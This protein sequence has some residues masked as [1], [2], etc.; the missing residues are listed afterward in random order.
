LSYRGI[1]PRNRIL[2]FFAHPGND[3]MTNRIDIVPPLLGLADPIEVVN[4]LRKRWRARHGNVGYFPTNRA[5]PRIEACI[6]RKLAT[7]PGIA[8]LKSAQRESLRRLAREGAL[9]V[10]P[11]TA[12]EV[13]ELIAA[14]HAEAPWMSAVSTAI[15]QQLLA[16]LTTGRS[17][18]LLRPILLVGDPGC[19]KSH[20]ARRLGELAA[21]P[22]RRIDVGGGSAGFRISGLE[23]GWSGT[24]PGIPVETVLASRTAN[25]MMIVDEVDKAGVLTKESGT[26]TS[27]TT[28][29]LEMLDLGTAAR[30]GC[31]AYRV[32]FDLSRLCW[33]LT[34]NDLR[35]VPAPLRDRCQIFAVP[36][37][38]LGDLV[39]VYDHLAQGIKDAD[40]VALGRARLEYLAA[41][42]LSLRQLLAWVEVLRGYDDRPHYH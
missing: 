3:T 5:Q 13:D 8:E 23:K 16:V 14:L 26:S 38:G 25:P 21:L 20:Y 7:L 10:G 41:Q 29:L 22:V 17:G 30:F 19:G 18:L 27:L 39:Q 31:P 9:V 36:R 2:H 24:C 4:A 32:P 40:L 34:A 33:I 15:R 35:S 6:K 11:K 37:P 28:S 12:H 42:G 1:R